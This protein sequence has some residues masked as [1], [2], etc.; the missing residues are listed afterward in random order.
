MTKILTRIGYS[1]VTLIIFIIVSGYIV[2]LGNS[3]TS[4]ANKPV[5]EFLK[6]TFAQEISKK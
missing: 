1:I 6:S 5:V 4:G 2:L 3:M